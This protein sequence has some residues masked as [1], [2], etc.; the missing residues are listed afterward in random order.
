MANDLE[1][2]L[3]NN[4]TEFANAYNLRSTV[5]EQVISK[6]SQNEVA[7]EIIR[8]QQFKKSF[9]S[10]VQ[11]VYLVANSDGQITL[12]IKQNGNDLETKF[13]SRYR[14][15]IQFQIEDDNSYK[16]YWSFMNEALTGKSKVYLSVDGIYNQMNINTLKLP[17]GNYLGDGLNIISVSSTRDIVNVSG[18]SKK[19]KKILMFGNPDYGGNG[20]IEALPGTKQELEK[21]SKLA[22]ANGINV[23]TYLSNEASEAKFKSESKNSEVLHIATHG[24]FL[25]DVEKDEGVVF[26]VEIS[27]AKENPL[28]RSGLLLAGAENTIDNVESK[29]VNSADNG[30]LTAYEVMSMDLSKTKLVV[31]SACETGLGEI[32]SGEGVYGLQRAFQLAGAETIIMSLWKVNDEATQQLMISF[33]SEWTKTGDKYNSFKL[34]QKNLRKKY[35]QPYYWG[36]FIMMN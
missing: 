5:V 25:D 7:I 31:L 18:S 29:E 9:S 1:K 26:G 20:K 24:F 34:A 3:G 8:F 2:I 10:E 17:N 11:Y 32:R 30:I 16:E 33:Y 21:I 27:Q 13:A 22:G 4:S 28:L 6:L 12:L 19:A 35:E 36:A 14:K 23:K 15:S